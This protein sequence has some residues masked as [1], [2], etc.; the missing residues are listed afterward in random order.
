MLQ[1]IKGTHKSSRGRL[2]VDH[3]RIYFSQA[4]ASKRTPIGCFLVARPPNPSSY[5]SVGR[6]DVERAWGRFRPKYV[7]AH[8]PY[9]ASMWLT[10]RGGARACACWCL[11]LCGVRVVVGVMGVMGVLVVA[12]STRIEAASAHSVAVVLFAGIFRWFRGADYHRPSTHRLRRPSGS[13]FTEEGLQ[14][15]AIWGGSKEVWRHT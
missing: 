11:R 14:Q 9:G 2:N 8:A 12:M 10:V 6:G 15:Q 7:S 13:D 1:I 5:W 4:L 3:G